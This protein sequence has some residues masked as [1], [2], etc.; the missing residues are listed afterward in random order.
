MKNSM[1]SNQQLETFAEE[2][3]DY[4]VYKSK[5]EFDR[6]KRQIKNRETVASLLNVLLLV[7]FG[8]IEIVVYIVAVIVAPSPPVLVALSIHMRN[9]SV[10][11]TD[12]NVKGE[13][14]SKMKTY[15]LDAFIFA[16]IKSF[17]IIVWYFLSNYFIKLRKV[18]TVKKVMR[19]FVV[20]LLV[21]TGFYTM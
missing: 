3:S 15:A 16:I 13:S 1:H 21:W 11:Y 8:I 14:E 19:W 10:N 2:I 9:Y 4:T 5:L 20:E 12:D 17:S 18:S 7:L 6:L